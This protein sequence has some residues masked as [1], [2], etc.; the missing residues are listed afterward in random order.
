MAIQRPAFQN[1]TTS[2]Q[3]RGFIDER[4]RL[5]PIVRLS[6]ISQ[7]VMSPLAVVDEELSHINHNLGFAEYPIMVDG[8]Q[9]ATLEQTWNPDR[10]GEAEELI[11][12]WTLNHRE[13][14]YDLMDGWEEIEPNRND[15]I[16][17][18]FGHNH[19]IKQVIYQYAHPLGWEFTFRW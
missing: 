19:T 3:F 11:T 8:T 16:L 7:E 10:G 13:N 18:Y 12:I 1:G 6:R 17:N 9:I 4:N 15:I 2:W 14:G 5:T